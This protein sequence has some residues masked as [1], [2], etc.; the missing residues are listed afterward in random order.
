MYESNSHVD[1]RQ[2][3]YTAA[4][5]SRNTEY[6]VGSSYNNSLYLIKTVNVSW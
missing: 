3:I 4:L 6:Y 5:F 1:Q 2:F